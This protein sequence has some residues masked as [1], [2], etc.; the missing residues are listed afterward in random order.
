M[1]FSSTEALLLIEQG[2]KKCQDWRFLVELRDTASRSELSLARIL[3]VYS[4]ISS[5]H[6]LLAVEDETNKSHS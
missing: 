3:R 6:F 4:S 5:R 2:R 1:V